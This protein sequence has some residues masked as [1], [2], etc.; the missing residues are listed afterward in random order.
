LTFAQS[1]FSFVWLS[2]EPL[3]LS[4]PP[5]AI[6][7]PYFFLV[8]AEM[9]L[10]V[11]AI[12]LTVWPQQPEQEKNDYPPTTTI[13]WRIQSWLDCCLGRK[14][15]KLFQLNSFL[16][17]FNQ[18]FVVVVVWTIV[19]QFSK[20]DCVIVL[21]L[22]SASL[23]LHVLSLCW[24]DNEKRNSVL[25]ICIHLIPVIPFLALVRLILVFQQQGG[26]CY[27][28]KDANFWFDGCRLCSNGLPPKDAACWEKVINWNN[29]TDPR[30]GEYFTIRNET[31]EWIPLS[32]NPL[33]IEQFSYCGEVIEDQFCFFEY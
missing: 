25:L 32:R 26:V 16:L 21:L 22:E 12:Q 3:R 13:R 31:F 11:Q 1:V 7:V 18:F 6:V 29:F 17:T 28:V 15:Q 33:G 24:G 23:L 20:Q 30:T 5:L 14:A 9:V 8:V 10:L 27:L 19:F 2:K 4:F